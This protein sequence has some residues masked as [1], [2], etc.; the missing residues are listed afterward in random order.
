MAHDYAATAH[1]LQPLTTLHVVPA[2]TRE[3]WAA[4]EPDLSSDMLDE[5]TAKPTP[6]R[7]AYGEVQNQQKDALL[8]HDLIPILRLYYIQDNSSVQAINGPDAKCECEACK[9]FRTLVGEVQP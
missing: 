5:V 8:V 2:R 3:E 7:Y 4:F 9:Q 6:L 1:K